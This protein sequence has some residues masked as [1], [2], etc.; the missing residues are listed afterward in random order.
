MAG[1]YPSKSH[2]QSIF[3]HL[4]SADFD[5]FLSHAL[6]D[7][8]WTIMSTTAL[9]TSWDNSSAFCKE[10][11]GRF[12]QLVDPAH[13]VSLI[14]N[15]IVGGGDEPCSVVEMRNTA[16]SKDGK[17]YDQKY[18]W[19][20]RWSKDGDQAKITEGRIYFDS[21]LVDRVINACEK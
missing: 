1:S 16:V 18:A 15:N 3:S 5:T 8:K 2:I 21:G 19:V 6:P 17:P 9:G 7:A 14:I 12:S 10:T 13:P 20:V 4:A 11:F